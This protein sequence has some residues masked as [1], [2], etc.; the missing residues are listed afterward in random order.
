MGKGS[1]KL[2]GEFI[3]GIPD[4][5]LQY[6]S[7]TP[8][9]IYKERNFRLDMQGK[10]TSGGWNLQIQVNRGATTKNLRAIA[11]KT[12]AGPVIITLET[13]MT[14]DE[15]RQEFRAKIVKFNKQK[16]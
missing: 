12:I 13:Y 8:G 16:L 1:I 11:P 2:L 4:E 5:K 10:T 15:I 7:D 3:D 6:F 14:P 9:L